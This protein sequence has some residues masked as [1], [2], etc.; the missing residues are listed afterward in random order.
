[1]F[2]VALSVACTLSAHPRPLAGMLP[3][4]DRTFLSTHSQANESSGCPIAQE[5]LL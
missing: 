3:Y 2:S 4:E 5:P 1:M